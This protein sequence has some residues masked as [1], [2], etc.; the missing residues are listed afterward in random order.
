MKGLVTALYL[1][2]DIS[3]YPRLYLSHSS[4]IAVKYIAV[5]SQTSN[6]N[7]DLR[8]ATVTSIACIDLEM[9]GNLFELDT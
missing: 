2:T 4:M 3:L 1:V 8:R 7:A 5:Q 9:C 6:L